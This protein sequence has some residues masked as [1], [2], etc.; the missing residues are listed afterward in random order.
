MRSGTSLL[1]YCPPP[2]PPDF[3]VAPPQGTPDP[4]E[5][6]SAGLP[7]PRGELRNRSAFC[8]IRLLP[9]PRGF[10]CLPSPLPLPP[11]GCPR[12]GTG[13]SPS[14]ARS[15]RPSRVC[16]RRSSRRSWR[17]DTPPSLHPGWARR[18]LW[19]A[20]CRGGGVV[21]PPVVLG[22]PPPPT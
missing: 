9:N 13:T 1:D 5:W 4:S 21:R 10:C 6:L 12:S 16:R 19:I 7:P 18:A 11:G 8:K 15:R 20:D 2:L 17:C 3:P 14:P 22:G